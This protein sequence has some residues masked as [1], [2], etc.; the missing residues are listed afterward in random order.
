MWGVN[1]YVSWTFEW[2]RARVMR[3]LGVFN[4]IFF[5]WNSAVSPLSGVYNNFVYAEQSV[6]NLSLF[7]FDFY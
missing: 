6:I 4:L 3:L 2:G 1:A 5:G 7:R